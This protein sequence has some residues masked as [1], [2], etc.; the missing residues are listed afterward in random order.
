MEEFEHHAERRRENELTAARGPEA[1][2]QGL[3]QFRC[4]CRR[5]DCDRSVRVPLY[6]FRRIVEAGDQSLVQSG[7]HAFAQ[8]RTIVTIGLMRIEE[9][10]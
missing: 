10:A 7:H 9:R 6:V 2:A 8:Y 5:G 3:V 1:D 4:E